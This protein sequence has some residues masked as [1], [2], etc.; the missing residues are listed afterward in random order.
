MGLAPLQWCFGSQLAKQR[1]GIGIVRR[2][3]E[4][5]LGDAPILAQR[6]RR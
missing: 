2:R 4:V 1:V 6:V 3:I 5:D